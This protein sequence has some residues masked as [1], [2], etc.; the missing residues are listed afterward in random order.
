MRSLRLVKGTFAVLVALSLATIL[1]GGAGVVHA[2]PLNGRPPRPS[3][4]EYVSTKDVGQTSTSAYSYTLTAW[5]EFATDA[6]G[7][8]V[9]CWSRGKAQ[10]YE[11]GN[12]IG[13][14]LNIQYSD[15]DVIVEY[16]NFSIPGGGGTF[17]H[18][19]NTTGA[20]CGRTL[21]S[22]TSSNGRYLS[23][24]TANQNY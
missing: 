21:A 24:Q 12:L 14:T 5:V 4:C 23:V 8:N 16:Q 1:A 2:A 11:N 6:S 19:T 22:F 7:F 17:T 15:C 9:F 18:V 20:Q 13:G 3:E 10:V